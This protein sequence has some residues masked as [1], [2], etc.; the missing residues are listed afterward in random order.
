MSLHRPFSV[1]VNV[2]LGA[3]L[4]GSLTALSAC[5][6]DGKTAPATCLDPPLAI[7]DIQTGGVREDENPCTTDVGHGI[8]SIGSS[9]TA[10]TATGGTSSGGKSSSGGA[11]TADAGAG[12]AGAGAGAGGAGGAGGAQ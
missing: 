4:L 3:L 1:R 12:G 5:E 6:E 10:G 8:S 11:P 9:T 7:Y 2:A